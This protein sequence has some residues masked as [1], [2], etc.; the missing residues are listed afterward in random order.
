MD[1]WCL[2]ILLFASYNF[3]TSSFPVSLTRGRVIFSVLPEL[4][5]DVAVH[6]TCRSRRDIHLS[7]FHIRTTST[8]ASTV[9]LAAAY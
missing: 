8:G 2:A 7:P 1:S 9:M 5:C 3:V 4:S 6:K